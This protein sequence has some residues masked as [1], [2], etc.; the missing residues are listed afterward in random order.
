MNTILLFDIEV[1][2]QG[3]FPIATNDEITRI[4]VMVNDTNNTQ[5]KY[6]LTTL[7]IS[8]SVDNLI[9]KKY[10]N[11]KDLIFGFGNLIKS[12]NPNIISG[13]AISGFSFKYIR[14]RLM[15][16]GKDFE[17][18]FRLDNDLTW[19][20]CIHKGFEQ[21]YEYKNSKTL[22]LHI[23]TMS[24][25]RLDSY[26]LTEVLK[27]LLNI[28]LNKTD[29]QITNRIFAETNDVIISNAVD[30][31]NIIKEESELLLN[32]LKLYYLLNN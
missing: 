26:I 17:K 19:K 30:R 13:Y 6:L 32:N 21:Y 10:S 20:M 2:F 11:E 25:Y 3:K 12:S 31:T 23:E 5:H 8:E 24:K 7:N 1:K 18:Q 9:I 27:N 22:D 15:Q 16:Y 28:D 4:H 14:D 29:T